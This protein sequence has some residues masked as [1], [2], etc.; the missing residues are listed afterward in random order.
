MRSAEGTAAAQL[1]NDIVAQAVQGRAYVTLVPTWTITA[2]D[3]GAYMPYFNDLSGR[4]RLMRHA[5]GLHFT[6]PGYELLGQ[7]A[8]NKLLE[9]SPRFKA[10][11][12]PAIETVVR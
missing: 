1:T 4:K 11:A 9:V 3:R 5:D 12:T 7:I 8:F 6:E 2:D 10:V